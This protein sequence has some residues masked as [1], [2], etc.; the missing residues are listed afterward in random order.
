MIKQLGTIN[1]T[2]GYMYFYETRAENYEQQTGWDE[3]EAAC[4]K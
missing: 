4:D 1:K 2:Q 3:K